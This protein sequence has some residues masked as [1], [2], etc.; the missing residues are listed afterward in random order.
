MLIRMGRL[1]DH[2]QIQVADV[3]RSLRFYRAVV[4]ALN[5]RFQFTRIGQCAQ[6]DEFWL[7]PAIGVA[8]SVHIAFQAA[9]RRAVNRFHEAGVSNEGRCNG[10][11]GIRSY[12]PDYYSAYLFDPDGNN[13]EAVFHG[14]STRSAASVVV[15]TTPGYR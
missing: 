7:C 5:R 15:R 8:S 11:P 3:D 12:H 2:V 6:F 1:L 4:Q 13:I 10:P 9:S 14:V